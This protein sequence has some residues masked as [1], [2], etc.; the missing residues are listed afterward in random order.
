MVYSM[1]QLSEVCKK[2]KS[3]IKKKNLF[4]FKGLFPKFYTFVSAALHHELTRFKVSVVAASKRCKNI[5]RT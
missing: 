4:F 2:K 5:A 1:W 3:M